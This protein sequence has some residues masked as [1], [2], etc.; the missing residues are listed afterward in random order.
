[1]IDVATLR[2]VH[3]QLIQTVE[4][5]REIHREGMQ[6]RRHAEVELAQLREEV[7]QRLAAPAQTP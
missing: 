3:E 2:H 6:Q 5:V 4:E 7:Q 1:M